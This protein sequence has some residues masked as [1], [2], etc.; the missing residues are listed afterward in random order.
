MSR[1]VYSDKGFSLYWPS[2]ANA[3][4]GYVV[5]WYEASCKRDCPVEWIKVAAGNTNVSLESGTT[6]L[7]PS[8]K[9]WQSKVFS[10]LKGIFN[11]PHSQTYYQSLVFTNKRPSNLKL[12][13]IINNNVFLCHQPTS[14]QVWGTTFP[15]TAAHQSL[16][17]C[18]SAGK[19]TCRSWV[20]TALL[21]VKSLSFQKKPN[22]LKK[23]ITIWIRIADSF[24]SFSLSLAST[25]PS[26]PVSLSAHQQ[27]S[28]I[29]LTWGDIPLVNRRG[30][31]LGYN[32]YVSN[33]PQLTLLG[34]C[35][36]V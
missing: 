10:K 7:L 21:H 32:I 36:H 15:C 6:A 16:Q 24:F 9:A 23:K 30:F 19:D 5:E 14:S 4:C 31:I 33:G 22:G 13:C 1:A 8:L 34:K 25:V 2:I 11:F 29:L 3:T 35:H 27:D 17:S 28:E 12:F 26:S 20:R 18:C